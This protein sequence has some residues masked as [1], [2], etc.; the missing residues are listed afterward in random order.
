M[1]MPFNRYGRVLGGM[2]WMSL[3]IFLWELIAV[4][5]VVIYMAVSMTNI[6]LHYFI[7]YPG[8]VFEW[9]SVIPGLYLVALVASIPAIVVYF[10]YAMTPFILADSPGVPATDALQLS[11]KMMRGHKWELFVMVLSFLGWFVLSVITFG[12]LYVFYVGPYWQASLAGFYDEV[13]RDALQKGIVTLKGDFR[14]YDPNTERYYMAPRPAHQGYSGQ[15]PPQDNGWRQ[16]HQPPR[17]PYQG[18]GGPQGPGNG[19]GA[20]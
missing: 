11:V 6:S 7:G 17:Q 5:A 4:A 20:D 18:G 12:V 15:Q 10:S 8:S 14:E 19:N 9:W 3:R 2:L 16:S 13:K 1:F